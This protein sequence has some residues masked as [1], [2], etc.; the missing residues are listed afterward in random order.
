[1][2]PRNDKA[3]K[4]RDIFEFLDSVA[5]FS[6]AQEW[7]NSGLLIGDMDAEVS[8]A[9]V[10]LD[11]TQETIIAAKANSAELIITHHP[12]IFEPLKEIES[13]SVVW[14]LAKNGI[15]VISAHT[16]L[17]IAPNG[18][19]AQ[20]CQKLG[21]ESSPAQDEPFLRI[22]DL[23]QPQSLSSLAGQIKA[24]LG[25]EVLRAF[26]GYGEAKKIAVCCGSG[27]DLL[28]AAKSLG[29]DTLITGDVKHSA[30]IEA[31]NIG[32]NI[33]DAGHFA[34]EDIVVDPLAEM[35]AERFPEIGFAAVHSKP[36]SVFLIGDYNTTV[37][38]AN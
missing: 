2:P 27:G 23:D 8:N 22:I 3:M 30:F 18:V 14:E 16:N 36:F 13:G 31:A 1:M 38:C 10:S 7:D 32:M 6:S 28:G 26:E 12:V 25:T 29:C 33:L 4:I 17:D 15:S 37:F 34:T 9:I 24:S 21:F 19:N 20:L 11:C 5:P 35:L